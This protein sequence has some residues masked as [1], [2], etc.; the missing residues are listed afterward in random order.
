MKHSRKKMQEMPGG[1]KMYGS[2]P[3]GG[4]VRRRLMEYMEKGGKLKMV[5][6]DK[7]EM[8]PFFAAD[9]KGKMEAGGK[10]RSYKMGQEGMKNDP[11]RMSKNA[12]R[13]QVKGLEAERDMLI[14]GDLVKGGTMFAE[15]N[16]DLKGM[17][18]FGRDGEVAG[19]IRNFYDTRIKNLEAAFAKDNPE[20]PELKREDMKRS[21]E[22]KM[23]REGKI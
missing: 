5:K 2:M 15:A 4:M 16:P 17:T 14:A 3:G 6:N 23:K 21:I 22:T 20:V 19:K 13:R 1:G 9:G 8:V 11:P 7:G 12:L 18:R 10:M